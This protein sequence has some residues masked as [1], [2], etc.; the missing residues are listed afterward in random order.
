MKL[1]K[2]TASIYELIGDLEETKRNESAR[3]KE[4]IHGLKEMSL[5]ISLFP[6]N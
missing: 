1:Y 3:A 6:S 5:K 4:T 2:L